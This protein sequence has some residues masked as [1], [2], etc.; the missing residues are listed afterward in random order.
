MSQK[1]GDF[2]VGIVDFFSVLLP[3]A[4]LAFVVRLFSHDAWVGKL[5]PLI[6]Q[7]LPDK[8]ERWIAFAFAS[9]VIG[10]LVFHLGALLDPTYNEL[11][12]KP[13][14]GEF[15][16][17]SKE[18]SLKLREM[19]IISTM[20]AW[21]PKA[22]RDALYRRATELMTNT[23]NITASDVQTL[24]WCSGYVRTHSADAIA[25]VDGFEASQKFFRSMVV[26]FAIYAILCFRTYGSLGASIFA[27]LAAGSYLRY[28]RL[29]WKMTQAAF[30]FYIQ[31][32]T[33]E[34]AK[35]GPAK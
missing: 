14:K 22:N 12:L 32:R 3:G 21:L 23:D 5:V 13:K 24:Q 4:F 11:Y 30:L 17:L 16:L 28:C 18:R 29:R 20:I 1:P 31:L 34:E 35:Q 7:N 27:V 19:P 8:N 10:H 15:P 25:L 9:F 2:F 26:V 6:D 33:A